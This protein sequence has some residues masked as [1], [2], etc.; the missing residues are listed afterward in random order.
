VSA[1]DGIRAIRV[2]AG[3]EQGDRAAETAKI[4]GFYSGPIFVAPGQTKRVGLTLEAGRFVAFASEMLDGQLRALGSHISPLEV[5]GK[6]RGE[7]PSVSH[8]LRITKTGFVV[9]NLVIG[10]RGSWR[11]ENASGANRLV[12]ISKL[13][14][15]KPFED[16]V[17][18]LRSNNRGSSPLEPAER[19][20]GVNTI[21]SGRS[22][23]VDFTFSTGTYVVFDPERNI[24]QKLMVR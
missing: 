22:V 23:L 21:S 11:I 3:L 16:A 6:P 10:G 7:T 17:R 13:L 12:F 20:V 5:V 15:F 8:D 4:K 14:P 2:R 1:Q 19:T 24:A 9:P 18:W